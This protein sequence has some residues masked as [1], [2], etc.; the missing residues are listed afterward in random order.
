MRALLLSCLFAVTL[1]VSAAAAGPPAHGLKVIDATPAF[2]SFWD[3]AAGKSD[4]RRA[5]LFLERVVARYPAL[6]T[7]AVLGDNSALAGA[8]ARDPAGTAATYLHD[9]A[10]Y[11][12]A[13]RRL[14]ALL[15]NELA[16]YA[17]DFTAT[18]PDFAP[19]TPVYFTVSLFNF[20]GGTREV[21]GKPALLFG[22]DGIA[23]F[24]APDASLKV[25]FDHELF[26]QYRDQIAPGPDSDDQ[27]PLWE[28]LWEEGLATYVSQQ[29][30]PGSSVADALMSPTLEG[31]AQPLLPALAQEL[32]QNF[33]SSDRQEYAAFFFGRNRRPDL[34]PRCGYYVGYRVAQRLA[35]GRDLRELARLHGPELEA[36]VRAAL[37]ILAQPS[38]LPVSVIDAGR[39]RWS[40]AIGS[41]ARRIGQE[42]DLAR[43]PGRLAEM[44]SWIPAGHD[45]RLRTRRGIVQVDRRDLALPVA[46]DEAVV[47]RV[48]HQLHGLVLVG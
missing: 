46:G 5:Q 26:H 15:R 35:V 16:G 20:D 27:G 10:P 2:W 28:A 42:P 17:R 22:I 6:F 37:Q 19:T 18:F 25:F 45:H 8:D 30:N 13:M 23:R 44:Q 48:E 3:A 40:L 38:A 41:A 7:A 39:E 9:V 14:S 47:A 1:P 4:P 33:A 24:H 36:E 32:L 31:A 29:M 21:G 12:P 43:T 11:V 34:P